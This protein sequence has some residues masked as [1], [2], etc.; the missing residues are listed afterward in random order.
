MNLLVKWFGRRR[1]VQP[2]AF[3]AK[4]TSDEY[5]QQGDRLRDAR[6][7]SAAADAYRAALALAPER[8]DIWV[9]FANMLKDAGN[10]QESE[11]GYRT[12]LSL[13]PLDPDTHV[14]LGHLF[15]LQGRR[16]DAAASYRRA[17][18]IAPYM[19]VAR[20]ELFNAG[21]F[22]NQEYMFDAELRLGS[23][24]KLWELS[25]QLEQVRSTIDRI[26]DS[27]PLCAIKLFGF[28]TRPTSTGPFG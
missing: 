28:S 23:I 25:H 2:P 21:D 27:L 16:G 24:D 15:K 4:K 3:D 5:I 1:A 9:Q 14:Q 26:A 19:L 11:A 8:P 20:Q 12:A 13:A 22:V 6:E 18:E 17:A 7:F 10:F